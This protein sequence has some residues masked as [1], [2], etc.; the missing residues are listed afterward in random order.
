M[1][2]GRYD[3]ALDDKGRTMMPKRFR[4]RLAAS[5]DRSIWITNSMTGGPHLEARPNSAFQAFFQKVSQ[6]APSP[7]IINFRR[8]YFGAAMEVEV[9]N[10]GRILVPALLRQKIGLTDRIAFVGSH[11]QTFEIWH[12]DALDAQFAEVQANPGAFLSLLP[13]L[14][15]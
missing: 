14:S 1:F 12:P 9:D 2:A 5:Q 3:H 15:G 7:E 6:L 10:A 4:D 13:E 8:Y 11:E